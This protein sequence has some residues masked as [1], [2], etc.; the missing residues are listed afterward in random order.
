VTPDLA[1][2]LAKLLRL[3]C[4]RSQ[5][6][7]TLAAASRLSAIAAAHDLDWDRALANGGD[8]TLDQEA[9]S[10]LYSEGHARGV[11]ETEQRLRPQRDWTPANGT[12]A[13]AGSD[14][15]RV[16]RILDAAAQNGSLLTEWESNW[17]DSVR[18][19]FEQYGTRLYVSDKMW[20]IFDRLE[21]K[22]KRAGLL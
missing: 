11:A 17:S 8:S 21:M 4:D 5:D 1:A 3:I 9:A 7:E 16:Q 12:S 19:R 14:A 13:E 10:R 6:G 22:F 2:R 18:E 20:A 15:E